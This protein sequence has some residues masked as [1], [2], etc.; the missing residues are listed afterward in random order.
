MKQATAKLSHLKIAPRK[1]R[2]VAD[3]IKGLPVQEAEAQLLMRPQRAAAPLLKLLRSAVANAKDKELDLSKLFVSSVRVDKGPMLKRTSPRA[4]GRATLIQ[5]KS[6]H[7]I[8]VLEERAEA[9][10]QRFNIEIIKK[11]KKPKK[12]KKKKS[13]DKAQGREGKKAES[14]EQSVIKETTPEKP[15]YRQKPQQ[16]RKKERQGF[17]KRIFKRKSV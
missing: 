3:S 15:T 1:T 14:T 13:L 16:E 4:M 7:I 6:S 12:E 2:L 17:L 5:K 9:S 11:E 10:V 8:L